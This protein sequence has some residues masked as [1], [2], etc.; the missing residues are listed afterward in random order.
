MDRN[1]VRT[2]HH[3]AAV[4][5]LGHMAD[6]PELVQMLSEVTIVVS[7]S[8]LIAISLSLSLSLSCMD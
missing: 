1:L 4:S 7:T 3:L 6:I 5:P 2:Y 8:M